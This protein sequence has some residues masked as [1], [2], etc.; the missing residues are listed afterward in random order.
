MLDMYKEEKV[1][2]FYN[3]NI[4][5]ILCSIRVFYNHSNGYNLFCMH[6][7][8]KIYLAFYGGKN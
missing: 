6:T 2:Y 4:F 3:S 5:N 7:L 8:L 1:V